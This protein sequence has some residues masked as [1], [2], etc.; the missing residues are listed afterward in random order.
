MDWKEINF[1]KYISEVKQ[2]MKISLADEII[3]KDLILTFILA[4]FEKLGLGK[5]LIFKG[6]TLLSRN[7]LK[8]H[9]F[10]EDL[11]FVFKDS[12][13]IRLTKRH[14][15]ERKIKLFIDIFVP[16]LKEVADSLDLDFSIDRSN[17]KYCTIFL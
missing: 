12:N 7:Y 17:Q 13:K 2:N 6:G 10:S 8:Y 3:K 1:E 15:R 9:R 5:E 4:E 16:K 11:D 14:E